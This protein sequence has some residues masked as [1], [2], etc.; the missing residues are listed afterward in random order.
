MKD[1]NTITVT[2]D[3]RLEWRGRTYRCALGKAGVSAAKRE[4]DNATP[5]GC[6]ALRRGFFRPDRTSAPESGLGFS[7]MSKFDG[8]CDDPADPQYNRPVTLPYPASAES[9]WREDG[10]YDLLVELGYSD[11]PIVPGA[12]SAIFLHLATAGFSPTEGCVA[13]E[14]VDLLDVLRRCDSE[15]MLC[16]AP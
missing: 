5:A 14:R 8:W 1:A 4:G 15:T 11:D 13:L 9:L 10:V 2:A 16:V 3:G 6:F 12:G 7:P